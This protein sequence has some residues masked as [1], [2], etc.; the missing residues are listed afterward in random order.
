MLGR[1]KD[2]FYR[3]LF[4]HP[5]VY[6][7]FYLIWPKK[8]RS[9]LQRRVDFAYGGDVVRS[10]PK[11]MFGPPAVYFSENAKKI[12]NRLREDSNESIN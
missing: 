6:K 10:V 4:R 7:F 9:R 12:L 8:N 1:K 11:E 5:L 2:K 3:F